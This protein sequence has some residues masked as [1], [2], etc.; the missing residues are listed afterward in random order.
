MFAV[1]CD[2]LVNA[3][4]S[5]NYIVEM[6]KEPLIITTTKD[7]D[8]LNELSSRYKVLHYDKNNI[9]GCEFN[10]YE[11]KSIMPIRD[12]DCYA[13]SYI[14]NVL[15]IKSNDNKTHRNRIDKYLMNECLKN[16]C[17]KY[18]KQKVCYNIAEVNE[19][20][21]N[22]KLHDYVIKP[23]DCTGGTDVYRCS[24]NEEDIEKC[25]KNIEIYGKTLIE[26]FLYGYENNVAVAVK[27]GECKVT[28]LW[29]HYKDRIQGY[30]FIPR[31]SK[32]LKTCDIS[33]DIVSY[34]LKALKALGICNGAGWIQMIVTK[35]GPCMTECAERI[36]GTDMNNAIQTIGVGYNLTKASIYSLGFEEKY[37]E[38]DD[39]Y[40][41]NKN[42]YIIWLCAYDDVIFDM[43]AFESMI[44]T[45]KTYISHILTMNCPPNVK[46][47]TAWKFNIG[48]INLMSDNLEEINDDYKIIRQ[49]EIEYMKN[50]ATKLEQLEKFVLM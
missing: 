24:S 1:V 30:D 49:W 6:G 34:S 41:F 26:E 47:T 12:S 25:K 7:D 39:I 40:Y 43:E 37:N 28:G 44:R 29:I 11:I 22:E 4:E 3:L 8:I 31:Y 16:A 2:R 20:I 48:N 5:I 45:L 32:L 35:E 19:F 13:A 27:D 9:D 10:K 17:L 14:G 38:L 42:G 36:P 46:K 23:L 33:D 18:K 50:S 21:D 15:G